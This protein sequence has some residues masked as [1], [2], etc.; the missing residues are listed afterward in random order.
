MSTTRE[1]FSP[2]RLAE[3]L[4]LP[5]PTPEQAAVIAAPLGPLLVV[6]GAGSGKTETMASRVVYLVANRMVRP[7]QVL[8]L[9][10][11]RKAAGELAQRVR[12]RL[13]Q[14]ARIPEIVGAERDRTVVGEP[15]VATYHSYA[16]RVVTEHGLRAGYEPT[17]RL[18]TEA[19]CWQLADAVVRGYDGDMSDVDLAPV[20]VTNE[21]LGLAA[22]MSEHLC[23]PDELIR[24]T[25]RLV[26]TVTR[27]P[28]TVSRDTTRLLTRQRARLQM[29]PLVERYDQRKRAAEAMDYG[30][31]LARAARVARDHPVVGA[32]E[33]D[34][35]RVVLLDEYQD[36]SHAQVVLLRALFGRG[37]PVTAV[38]D[39]AQSIYAWRGA[40]ADT[41]ERFP[42]DFATAAGVP[43]RRLSLTVS[44]R[45]APSI[46]RVANTV[47]A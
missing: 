33:R 32:G 9:T 36:T 10:F 21:V 17:T 29:L 34:R 30:D 43:A 24:H 2:H 27:I 19:A 41:L 39:P 25:R 13:T 23:G 6:A 3:L 16:A 42:A 8:G 37:H 35:Y 44:W 26:D 7:D 22:E 18:L 20:T 45:N 14:L 31:Q 5:E 38:G 47:S 4:G 1:R 11:T 46:L 15:T 28:G 40:S 12:A